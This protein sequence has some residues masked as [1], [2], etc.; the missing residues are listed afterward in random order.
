MISKTISFC[1]ASQSCKELV[2]QWWHSPHV[3]EFWDNSE[4]MWNNFSDYI[5]G[6]KDLY[7]YW[8]GACDED[9]FS[10]IITSD[11]SE[12]SPKYLKPWIATEGKTLTIDFMIGE[13][14]YLGKG[15]A[16]NT[17]ISFADFLSENISTLL[18]DPESANIK[19]IHVYEKAGFKKVDRFTPEDGYFAGK[20]HILMMLSL[21]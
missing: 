11:V 3:V 20:E 14:P 13:L 2:H 10:L 9:P 6:K 5:S 12:D 18:I 1:K 17:L 19:A 8:I 7:D 4:K 15:L 16:A 21:N